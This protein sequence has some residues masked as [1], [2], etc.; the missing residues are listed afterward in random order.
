SRVTA[1]LESVR[2]EQEA[3]LKQLQEILT[4]AQWAKVPERIKNPP[5]GPGQGQQRRRGA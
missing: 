4:P 1:R 5:R 3:V 2:P